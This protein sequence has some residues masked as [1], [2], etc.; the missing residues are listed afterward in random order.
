MGIITE[1]P[2]WVINLAIVY[3]YIGIIYRIANLVKYIHENESISTGENS[4]PIQSLLSKLKNIKLTKWKRPKWKPSVPRETSE[5]DRLNRRGG[6]KL[7]QCEGCGY[8]AYSLIDGRCARCR[9]E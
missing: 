9:R 5:Y 1:I 6:T 8:D 2:Q 4:L 3:M 7:L